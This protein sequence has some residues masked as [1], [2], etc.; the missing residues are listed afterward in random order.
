MNKTDEYHSTPIFLVAIAVGFCA[1]LLFYG[2]PLGISVL[3]FF[4][5]FIGVLLFVGRRSGVTAVRQNLWLFLPLIFFAGMIALRDN[6]FV[7]GL[8]VLAVAALLAYLLIYYAA[9][10]VGESG[11]MPAVLLPV[12]TAGKSLFTAVPHIREATG[13]SQV[14]WRNQSNLISIGRGGLLAMPILI[15]FTILLASADLVFANQISGLFSFRVISNLFSLFFQGLF[16][17]GISWT[18]TGGLAIVIDSKDNGALFNQRFAGLRRFRFLGFTESTTVLTL[19]NLLFLSFVVIQFRYLFGGDSNINLSGYTYSDYARRGFFELLA[20]A[21]LSLGLILGLEAITWRESKR[22]F[23]SYNLLSSF[24]IVLVVIML[25]SAFQR[26]RLY[27]AA[28][29]YTE[30]RLYVYVSIIWLG[31]L[32]FWFLYGLWRRPDRFA[33]GAI[34]VVMGFLVTLNLLNP[35]AFI[36]RQN[37]ARYWA[38][39]ALDANYLESLSA[40]AVPALVDAISITDS[41]EGKVIPLPCPLLSENGVQGT[42]DTDLAKILQ[43]GLVDRM[44]EMQEESDWRQWQSFKLSRWHAYYILFRLDA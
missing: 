9:G 39:G 21:I 28:F 12:Y 31:L 13:S 29:G 37:V 30:L 33:L 34:V 10:K 44:S 41:A 19:V 24:L 17:L 5:L 27:E 6:E 4:L 18:V 2:K 40:D 20:V 23:K 25:I 26:M 22:Q 42:C 7:S 8:N 16:I 35:D 11:L 32:L 15:V 1:N 14:I 38:G 36:V 43:K 3:L